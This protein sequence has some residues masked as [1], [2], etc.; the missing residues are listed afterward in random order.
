MYAQRLD[1]HL[2]TLVDAL[3]TGTYRPHAIRRHW[4]PKPGTHERRPLGIPTV[5]DRVV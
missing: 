1:A 5:R 4:I 3:R 2:P